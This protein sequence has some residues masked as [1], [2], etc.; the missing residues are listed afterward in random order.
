MA[1][2]I[3]KAVRFLDTDAAMFIIGMFCVGAVLVGLR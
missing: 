2:M 1:E 3:A